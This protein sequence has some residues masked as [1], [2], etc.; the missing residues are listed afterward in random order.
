LQ[1]AKSKQFPS[2]FK[3]LLLDALDSNTVLTTRTPVQITTIFFDCDNTLVLSE[4]LAFA[5]CALLANEILALHG[6][7]DR[8][9][10]PMLLRDFVGQ[11]FRGMMVS[12]QQKYG[13]AM[14]P[15]ELEAYVAREEDAVIEMLRA[16]LRPCEGVEEV[17]RKFKE[18]GTYRMAVVSSSA[19]RRVRAALEKVQQDKYFAKEDVFSAASSLPKPTSKPDPAIYLFA[20]ESCEKEPGECVA[21]EDSK[22]GTLSAVRAGL[23]VVG[24]VGSYEDE[25]REEMKGVLREAGA[26][27]MMDH[28]SQFE[29]CLEKI[30]RI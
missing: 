13:Y 19:L 15:L 22:S 9:T 29:E 21:I 26:C 27:V 25:K 7:A 6:F 2:L 16:E 8:Y 20:M 30:E 11:N 28:W 12:L 4:D 3:L 24:Y 1:N 14:D 17:L 10:G 5:A 23:K 18:M